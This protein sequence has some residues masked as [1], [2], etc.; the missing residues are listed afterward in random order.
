MCFGDS[1]RSDGADFY[2]LLQAEEILFQMKAD[3][4]YCQSISS[5][6][7]PSGANRSG[8]R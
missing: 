7:V 8:R 2:H 3:K 4:E 5:P 1:A 6:S